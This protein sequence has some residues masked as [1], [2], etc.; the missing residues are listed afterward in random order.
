MWTSWSYLLLP[1]LTG[2]RT[3]GGFVEPKRSSADVKNKQG[4]KDSTLLA[5]NEEAVNLKIYLKEEIM[6]Q[7]TN[8]SAEIT[9]VQKASNNQI[10]TLYG[11]MQKY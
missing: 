5:E 9:E 1:K 7:F 3:W 6:A 4:T 8:L 10:Q 11:E 2:D